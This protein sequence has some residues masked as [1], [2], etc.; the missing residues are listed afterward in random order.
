MGDLLGHAFP[1]I[2]FFIGGLW[3][4]VH[5]LP[6]YY[7]STC[8]NHLPYESKPWYSNKCCRNLPIE[9][10]IKIIVPSVA[11]FGEI[12]SETQMIVPYAEM[13][14]AQHQLMYFFF[15]VNGAADVLKFRKFQFLPDGIEVATGIMALGSEAFLFYNHLHG[16]SLIDIKCHIF[17]LNT[18]VA[19]LICIFLEIHY[20]NSVIP[21]LGRAYFIMLQGTWLIHVGLILYPPAHF[22]QWT[23]DSHEKLMALT[24]IFGWHAAIHLLIVFLVAALTWNCMKRRG[25][26]DSV[27]YN[28]MSMKINKSKH[29]GDSMYVDNAE[30]LLDSDSENV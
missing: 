24:T 1:G 11:F 25:Q 29:N 6:E 15:I 18:V 13:P 2:M 8:K 3:W 12:V 5:M 20:R 10:I 17:I 14:Q 19:A 26:L 21:S 22:P 23:E 28:T 7:K 4:L 16:R 9:G 30:Q 27:A